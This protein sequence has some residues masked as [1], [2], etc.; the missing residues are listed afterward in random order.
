MPLLIMSNNEKSHGMISIIRCPD[1][2]FQMI[3][4]ALSPIFK[5]PAKR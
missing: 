1:G 4:R 3:A 2:V 5:A